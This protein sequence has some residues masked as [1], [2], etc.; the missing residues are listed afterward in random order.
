MSS[1]RLRTT[2]SAFNNAVSLLSDEQK[3]AVRSFGFGSLLDFNIATLPHML[4]HFVV[5]NF[6][7]TSSEIRSGAGVIKVD[8]EA[9]HDVFGIPM[10]ET[11]ITSVNVAKEMEFITGWLAQYEDP[12]K[13][14]AEKQETE[15]LNLPG[16]KLVKKR[17]PKPSK[18]PVP[19]VRPTAIA[20]KIAENMGQVNE[21]FKMNFL[22]LFITSVIYSDHSGAAELNTLYSVSNNADFTT[23]DFCSYLLQFLGCCKFWKPNSQKHYHGP[24]TLL[25]V[26][27][28]SFT[29]LNKLFT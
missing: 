26:S 9:V 20:N 25:T 6:D 3:E 11:P 10:G 2:P 8:K 5:E 22:M 15:T 19:S 23:L 28:S 17:G 27:F 13:V 7:V 1:I 12:A 16:K 4:C 18:I 21:Y 29:F 24:A 14:E